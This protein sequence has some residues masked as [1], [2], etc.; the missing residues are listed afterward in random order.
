MDKGNAN[1]RPEDCCTDPIF[2]LSL[3]SHKVIKH[4]SNLS[5]VHSRESH[6]HNKYFTALNHQV[7]TV[8]GWIK[9]QP[10][11]E[12]DKGEKNREPRLV[13]S[14]ARGQGMIVFIL[15]LFAV[16]KRTCI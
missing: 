2:F 10:G 8:P 14:D 7:K 3:E 9:S 1:L 12:M 16:L 4:C 11:A 13:S 15:L 5:A 6:S